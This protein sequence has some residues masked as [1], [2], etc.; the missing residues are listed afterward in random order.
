MRISSAAYTALAVHFARKLYGKIIPSPGV[1]RRELPHML[2]GDHVLCLSFR[3]P[4]LDNMLFYPI[5]VL[6]SQMPYACN[7]IIREVDDALISEGFP[8][9]HRYPSGTLS[10]GA[11]IARNCEITRDRFTYD[12]PGM[13][14]STLERMERVVRSTNY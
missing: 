10:T 8:I 5:D 13:R 6:G 3:L 1:S 9:G 11:I 7:D 12:I 14:Q 2:Y 4:S